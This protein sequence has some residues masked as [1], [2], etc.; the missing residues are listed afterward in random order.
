MAMKGDT[1]GL[2]GCLVT[3]IG[4]IFDTSPM[5]LN[6]EL[7]VNKGYA[8]LTTNFVKGK[9]SFLQWKV[10]EDILEFKS[11]PDYTGEIIFDDKTSYIVR[12]K[13][14]KYGSDHYCNLIGIEGNK[15]RI[16]DTDYGDTLAHDK[17]DVLSIIKI[18]K[19]E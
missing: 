12:I 11:F 9:E 18:T 16:F 3:A 8:G 15:Y 4:N 14:R 19:V 6:N 10:A 7:K 2:Y 1:L 5:E 13:H 17:K